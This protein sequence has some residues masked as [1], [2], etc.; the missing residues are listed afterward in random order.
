MKELQQSKHSYD[1]L[2]VQYTNLNLEYT[3]L[4]K[5]I[6]HYK[7]IETDNNLCHKC[8]DETKIEIERLNKVISVMEIDLNVMEQNQREKEGLNE[9][10][11]KRE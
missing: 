1:D 10:V 4:K 5:D 11:N 8:L 2:N 9:M 6:E 3:K 7:Q